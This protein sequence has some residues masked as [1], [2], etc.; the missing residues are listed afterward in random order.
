MDD[1][2]EKS[3]GGNQI[4]EPR[5]EE[6]LL[7]DD[8]FDSD[9]GID[10]IMDRLENNDPRLSNVNIVAQ[11]FDDH[12]HMLDRLAAAIGRNTQLKALMFDGWG[13]NEALAMN[14]L[15]GIACNQS[16]KRIHFQKLA[17]C[18]VGNAYR[19]LTPLFKNNQVELISINSCHLSLEDIEGIR[20][21]T[22]SL[23]EFDSLKEFALTY[24][25]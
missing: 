18:D 16:I 12:R 14:F 6:E 9:L 2:I 4:E 21:L 13:F 1:R 19:I 15:R 20:L 5:E 10:D 11:N 7:S 24:L 25:C 3:Q 8:V 23:T 17:E 22:S